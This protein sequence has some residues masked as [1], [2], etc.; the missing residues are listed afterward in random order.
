[1][2]TTEKLRVALIG[3]GAMG[4]HHLNTLQ[5]SPRAEIAGA[6]DPRAD[7][8]EIK[9]ILPEQ[10][11]FFDDAEEMLTSLHPDVVHVVTPPST[12]A[13][14][15]RLALTQGAHVYI[16]KPFCLTSTDA[17]SVLKLAESRGLKVC[18]GHQLLFYPARREIRETVPDLKDTVHVESYFSFKS[19][20]KAAHGGGLMSP[21]EQLEDVLP[22]PVYL[23][24]DALEAIGS[25][26]GGG[27]IKVEGLDVDSAGEIRALIRFRET[28][29]VLVVSLRARP[30]ESYLRVT[31]SHGSITGDFVLGGTRVHRGPGTN[32]ISVVSRPFSEAFQLFGGAAS[33]VARLIFRK[34]HGYTGLAELV[35]EFYQAIK[36]DTPAPVSP[37]SILETVG[38]CEQ[39]GDALRAH[40]SLV[41]T[42][43]AARL[44]HEVRCLPPIPA[45]R[46]RIIVTGGTGF[47]GKALV[48]LLRQQSWP[49]QVITR[50]IPTPSGRVAGVDYVEL[51]LGEPL[52]EGL[53]QHAYAVVHLAAETLGGED[54]HRRNTIE[55]TRNLVEAASRDGVDRLIYASSIAVLLPG[56]EY[57]KA[58]D[59]HTPVDYDPRRGP[60]VW[61][62][63]QAEKLLGKLDSGHNLQYRIIRPGPLVDFS[64]FVA[65]GRLGREVGRLFVAIGNPGSSLSL[66]DVA[67]AAKVFA[68][69]VENFDIAPQ[70]LNLVEPEAPKRSSLVARLRKERPDLRVAWLPDPVMALLSPTLKLV[71]RIL[72]PGKPVID[73]RA[74][75]ASEN[76]DASLASSIVQQARSRFSRNSASVENEQESAIA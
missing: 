8:A 56:R 40:Q 62:K 15:A 55:A 75:F 32:A 42:T 37:A 47:L 18:A 13:E 46:E 44:E 58:V 36:E 2:V 53:L 3:C 10:A 11:R 70:T 49:V 27:E 71:Q 74:A 33:S 30:I 26:L 17:H 61:G 34:G 20:R 54:A 12:H 1:M 35:D 48:Q 73:V 52:P 59:E 67:T 63:A 31:G 16:E 6:S 28:R 65:P 29:A 72:R 7:A 25:E 5:A 14:L 68:W 19:V 51:D 9:K 38:L 60:Y 21:V 66:C 64:R 45:S 39:I 69:Y 4:K 23:L 24:V 50:R 43:V 22:H 41:D 76:Y 57:G